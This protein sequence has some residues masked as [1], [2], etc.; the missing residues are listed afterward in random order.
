M[1]LKDMLKKEGFSTVA[2][3]SD[4]IEALQL[5]LL[6]SDN[7]LTRLGNADK[8]T[9]LFQADSSAI[10]LVVNKNTT[11]TNISGSISFAANLNASMG[12]M[13]SLKEKIGISLGFAINAD[14]DDQLFFMFESPK[15]DAISSFVDLDDYLNQSTLIQNGYSNK[16]KD[17]DLYI[18]TAVLK[19][20]NFAIALV[21][22]KNVGAALELPTIKDLVKGD[23]TFG[24]GSSKQ[25]VYQYEGDKSLVFGIQAAQVLYDQSIWEK[26]MGKKGVFSLI[27]TDEMIMKAD[28]DVAVSLLK[29]QNLKF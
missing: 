14:S 15:M 18:I 24:T 9:R 11:I 25:R 5:L 21:S 1:Q 6:A 19:S 8:I 28:E 2:L 16:L 27:R 29:G 20:S 26:L 23:L 7:S 13:D 17:N 10:P 22:N 3:P 4:D 12:L